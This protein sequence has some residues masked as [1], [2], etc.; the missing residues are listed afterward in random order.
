MEVELVRH[1]AS[2]VPPVESIAVRASRPSETRL[3]FNY[4][5]KGDISGLV[6]PPLLATG[7]RADDLWQTTC[8]EAFLK[9]PGGDHYLEFNFSPSNQWASYLFDGYRTARRDFIWAGMPRLD[10]CAGPDAFELGVVVD[11][12]ETEQDWRTLDLALGLS[13]IIETRGDRR[14]SY[15]ALAHPPGEPDFHHGDCFA[16]LL[17]APGAA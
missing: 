1:P 16:A 5:V 4:R 8:F 13:A 9:R 12:S 10:I 15:W 11:L 3:I 17:R 7:G 6:M 2:P 14:K